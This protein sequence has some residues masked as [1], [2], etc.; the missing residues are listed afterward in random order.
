MIT[1]KER[2]EIRKSFIY[3][4]LPTHLYT[5][6]ASANSVTAALSCSKL[7]STLG[8]SFHPL[9]ACTHLLPPA[10]AKGLIALPGVP[11]LFS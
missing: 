8:H 7:A 6:D 3:L 2:I 10:F 5:A 1:G 4:F 9:L 11:A